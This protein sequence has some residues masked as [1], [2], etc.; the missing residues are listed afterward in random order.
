MLIIGLTGSI[1]TGKSTVANFFKELGAYIIDWDILAREVVQPHLKAWEGI[2]QYFGKDVLNE[3]M[4]LNRQKL[5]EIV[6][7]NKE[8]VEKLNQI[9]HPEIISEDDRITKQIT[10]RDPDALIVKD[11]PLLTEAY[12]GKLVDKIIVVSASEKTRLQRLEERGMN[13]EEA[14][15]RIQSQAPLDEKIKFADFV[16]DNDGSLEQTKMQVKKIYT[17]LKK[18][19]EDG[20]E[21]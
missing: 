17:L 14:K 8:K 12:R 7:L 11:I 6:F 5:A 13:Q 4:T 19:E 10:N 1:G 21:R 18:G 20:R 3:D 9:V 16:I 15:K 2:V